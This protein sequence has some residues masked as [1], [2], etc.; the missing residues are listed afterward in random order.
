VREM[1][2]AVLAWVLEAAR[3]VPVRVGFLRGVGYSSFSPSAW[4]GVIVSVTSFS[5][6]MIVI[7]VSLPITSSVRSLGRS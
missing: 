6:R 5:P 1:G 7:L 4:V 3:V 2:G